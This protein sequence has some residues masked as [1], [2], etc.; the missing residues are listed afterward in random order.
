MAGLVRTAGQT[1]M[2]P[3]AVVAGGLAYT[4]GIVDP[5][6]FG[7][8]APPFAAQAAAALGVLLRVLAD[9][10]TDAAHVV[11]L[12]AFL[13]DRADFAAWNEAYLKVWPAPGPA[14]TT[15][16]TGFALAAVRIEI[17]AVAAVP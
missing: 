5:D 13:A 4:S 15:I 11:K 12:E 7:P 9:A 8:Q 3:G 10:G 2:L 17:Q 16:V 1:P 14:R 6:V